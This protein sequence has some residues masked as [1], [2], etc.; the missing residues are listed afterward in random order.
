[1]S[2]ANTNLNP[3]GDMNLNLKMSDTTEIVCDNCG[4]TIFEQALMLRRVSALVSP[5]AQESVVPIQVMCCKKCHHVND[6]FLPSGL[7]STDVKM[8]KAGE[9]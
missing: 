8:S 4:H 9:K 2:N 7:K 1:M 6:A 3:Q 5:T